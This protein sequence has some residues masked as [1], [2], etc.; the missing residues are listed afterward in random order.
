MYALIYDDRDSAKPLKKV[1]S[2][3]RSRRTAENALDKRMKR[4]GKRVWECECRIVWVDG[5]VP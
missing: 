5:A 4:L 2:I 1:V 3:H